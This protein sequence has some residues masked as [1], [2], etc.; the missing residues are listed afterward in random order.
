MTAEDQSSDGLVLL[1]QIKTH[2]ERAMPW[3]G[4]HAGPRGTAGEGISPQAVEAVAGSITMCCAA[5]ASTWVKKRDL[6]SCWSSWSSQLWL[7][8]KTSPDKFPHPLLPHKAQ[9]QPFSSASLSHTPLYLLPICVFSPTSPS[10]DCC[11]CVSPFVSSFLLAHLVFPPPSKGAG[12][13]HLFPPAHLQ[14]WEEAVPKQGSI[15]S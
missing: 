1:S 8:G 3:P 11:S 12:F 4:Q 9:Q 14:P 5:A 6:A 13:S 10:P 7:Q 2:L 15:S